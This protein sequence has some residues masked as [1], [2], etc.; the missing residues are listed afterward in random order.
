MTATFSDD[1]VLFEQSAVEEA[2]DICGGM[3]GHAPV[4][5]IGKR[6]NM[7][8]QHASTII[9]QCRAPLQRLLFEHIQTDCADMSGFESPRQ[10]LL[11]DKTAP[12]GVDDD[13]A[14]LAGKRIDE[15]SRG[16]HQRHMQRD[17]IRLRE[18][19]WQIALAQA[20]FRLRRNGKPRIMI[21]DIAFEPG[22]SLHDTLPDLAG[23]DD[24][25]P[26]AGEIGYERQI[27]VPFARAHARIRTD[28]PLQRREYHC[29]R[30]LCDRDGIGAVGDRQPDPAMAQRIDSDTVISDTVPGDDL[31]IGGVLQMIRCEGSIFE[32]GPGCLSQ[33]RREP[34]LV[35]RFHDTDFETRL[36]DIQPALVYR[37]ADDDFPHGA[38]L[39]AFRERN[40]RHRLM[41]AFF[42]SSVRQSELAARSSSGPKTSSAVPSRSTT[43]S[44]SITF[45][46]TPCSASA[47]RSSSSCP[48]TSMADRRRSTTSSGVPAGVTSVCQ[49][50][51]SK[52][53]RSIAS[54]TVGSSGAASSRSRVVTAMP[55]V[56]SASRSGSTSSVAA[57]IMSM[58][59]ASRSW[60]A[61][62]PP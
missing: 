36:Q 23:A 58:L 53:S 14:R 44:W 49:N 19:L 9:G 31:Q 22:K 32:N 28:Q 45:R 4:R 47:A 20:E 13:D 59:P 21:R 5:G 1:D 7:R 27:A 38:L 43:A 15:I 25:N 39:A 37:A 10:C 24:Q 26:L 18:S 41:P 11:I 8:R 50:T 3:D 61:G 62:A 56:L 60:R 12:G 46:R 29:D 48:T 17:D 57:N 35:I 2:H 30:V 42:P 33:L 34:V 16:G 55:T 51:A 54:S 40:G 52:K 6:G